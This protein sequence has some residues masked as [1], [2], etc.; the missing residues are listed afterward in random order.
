M[1]RG[2][3]AAQLDSDRLQTTDSDRLQTT[4]SDRLQ[5]TRM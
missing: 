3:D 5:T 1:T 2:N 4:D